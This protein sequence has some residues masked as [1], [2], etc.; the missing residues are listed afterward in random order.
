MLGSLGRFIAILLEHHGGV[1][2]FWLSAEQVAVT[3]ISRD[4]ADYAAELLEAFQSTGLKAVC[5][6]GAETLSCRIVAA[7][8][9]AI[10]VMAIVGQQEKA[11]GRVILRERNGAQS[12]LTLADAAAALSA[13]C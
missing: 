5:Y 1:L 3:P 4:Q 10:P 12:E 2:P 13:R 11:S 8:E 9:A 7:R 6:D